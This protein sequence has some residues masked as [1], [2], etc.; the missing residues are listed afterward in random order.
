MDAN[1]RVKPQIGGHAL[2]AYAIACALDTPAELSFA[3]AQGDRRLRRGPT[4]QAVKSHL[5]RSS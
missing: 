5:D 2:E 4:L 3:A 1:V